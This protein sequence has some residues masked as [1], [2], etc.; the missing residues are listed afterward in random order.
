VSIFDHYLPW[1]ELRLALSDD[2]ELTNYFLPAMNVI[3]DQ[4]IPITNL[5]TILYPKIKKAVDL[6]KTKNRLALV[7]WYESIGK[8][9]FRIEEL[10]LLIK[11]KESE[12]ASKL[13]KGGINLVG[14][15]RSMSGLGDDIRGLII[16]LERLLIPYSVVCLGHPSD[17]LMYGDVH[18]EVLKPVYA[19]SIF[20]MNGF[21]FCKLSQVYKNLS[22]NYGYAVLQ[23]PWELPKLV[24]EWG[25]KLEVV[26]KIWAISKFVETA[27]RDAGFDNVVYNPPIVEVTTPNISNKVLRQKKPFTFLYV[28]DA[29]SYL[30]RKNP[31]AAV[32]CFQNAFRSDEN[33]RLILKI[34]NADTSAEF[35]ELERKC[36]ADKRIQVEKKPLRPQQIV[37]MINKC[38]CYL[39]LHRSEGF[40]RTIAQASL[41]AKPVIAT[42]WSGSTDILP[43]NGSLNVS[44][45]LIAVKESEYPGF[46]QQHWAEPDAQVAIEKLKEIYFATDTL[47]LQIGIENQKLALDRFTP[48]A[49]IEHYREQFKHIMEHKVEPDIA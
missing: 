35:A 26:D 2:V 44:Y 16:V 46:E 30:S 41:L 37:E 5:M 38:D 3:Q 20:C 17:N 1:T 7:H 12:G 21:E 32:H 33:V 4:R 9:T 23:A 42:D 28:F 13:K 27:F 45:T 15:A 29:A 22:D 34:S 39:S 25:P 36:S 14:Y 48:D 47:R 24:A 18:K 10:E 6:S 19:S 11:N 31:Q 49:S 40:G 43:H 8:K